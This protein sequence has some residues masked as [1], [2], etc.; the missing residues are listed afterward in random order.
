MPSRGL[1]HLAWVA[2]QWLWPPLHTPHRC[3]P[4]C[5]VLDFQWISLL[6][7]LSR[8]EAN[9]DGLTQ[10]EQCHTSA[11]GS[12]IHRRV[13]IRSKPSLLIA[14]YIKIK[15]VEL[16]WSRIAMAVEENWTLEEWEDI[17]KV[18]RELKERLVSQT[19]FGHISISS[20][21]IPMI[22]MVPE[23]PWKYFSI[24]TSHI[25]KRSVMA[26]ILGRST[27]NHHGTIY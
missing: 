5:P 13:M 10:P 19:S 22:L 27:S 12:I 20:S 17:E 18:R 7:V 24:D 1:E 14:N 3:L 6:E 8:M 4:R 21:M 2:E 15:R 25:S 16:I 11:A 9:L 26:E 23:S